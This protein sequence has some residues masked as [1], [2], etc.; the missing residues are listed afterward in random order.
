MTKV[1]RARRQVRLSRSLGIALTPKA[2]RIFEKRPYGPGEH[3]RDRRRAESDYAVRLREKQRLRA[4]Y[5]ISEKQMRAIYEK[6]RREAG[7][8]GNAMLVNLESRLDALVLRAGFARTS[9]Q[10]RQFVVH[11]H[12]LVDGN[13]VDRPSY[14]VKPGQTIQVKPKSQTMEPFQ[15]AAEGVHRDVLPAVPG[16]LDVNLAALKATLTRKPEVE[17]IPVTVNIQ[18]V[19]E[20]YSR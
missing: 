13:I 9:A 7:Q 5:G 12:I 1:Q 10:A 17:E 3:G 14:H 15:A 2:Q 20:H 19:V 11:R 6:S 16:Y 18:Y 8:T 4:Q